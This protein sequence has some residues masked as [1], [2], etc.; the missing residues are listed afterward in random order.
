MLLELNIENYALVQSLRIEFGTGLSAITGES[1]AGKS[2]LLGALGQVLGDRADPARISPDKTASQISALFDLGDTPGAAN[3]LKDCDLENTDAP[4][5]CL[6]HRRIDISGRSRAY[7]NDMSV[8]LSTLRSLGSHLIDIH[9]QDQHHALRTQQV[10]QAFFDEYAASAEEVKYL[11]TCWHTWQSAE[12]RAKELRARIESQRDRIDLLSYQAKELEQLNLQEGE[13]SQIVEAHDRLSNLDALR[14]QAGQAIDLLEQEDF[15]L[16]ARLGQLNA[17]LER[18]RD[19]HQA[20]QSAREGSA[21]ASSE[22]GLVTTELTRYIDSL[23]ADPQELERIDQRLSGIIDL[24]RKHRVQPDALFAHGQALR[25]ELDG[26]EGE[27]HNLAKMEAEVTKREKAFNCAAKKLGKLRREALPSFESAL[28]GYLERLGLADARI[29]VVLS[30]HVYERGF[31]KVSFD[32]TA[33]KALKA[34]PLDKVASGGERARLALAIELLAAQ[35]SQLPTLILDEADV[36]IGGRL[37]DEVGKLLSELSLRTQILMIT[38]APQAAARAQAHYRVVKRE[39]ES[40][41]IRE[42]EDDERLDEIT[43]MLGGAHLADSTREY[44]R[45]LLQPAKTT[46][47]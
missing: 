38:H 47:N 11:G 17:L 33:S 19:S 32:Y 9:A 3:F 29:Q 4:N 44:A 1:G 16:A 26:L 14:T 15:G 20:V 41:A 27:D 42:L 2:L 22:L 13:Y 6:L 24:A 21:A 7:V 5:E 34:I 46:P 23:Q 12:S 8:T 45:K 37:S 31:E 10:Q 28:H 30:E 35:R 39:D 40:V 25:A 36:G 43:R 18:M